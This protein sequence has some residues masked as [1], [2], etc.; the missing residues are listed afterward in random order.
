M[1]QISSANNPVLG[2]GFMLAA[3]IGFAAVNVATQYAGMVAGIHP[4]TT[5][6][7]QY[8]IA[9]LFAL[10]WIVR[11]GFGALATGHPI[12]HVG[13]VVLS[14]IGVQLWVSA[15]A[16]VPI[17]QGIAL[18]MTSPLFV[19]AGAVLFLGERATLLRLAATL[20]GFT[21]ALIIL[22][23]WSATFTWYA[24]LPIGA[25]ALWAGVTLLTKYLTRDEKSESITIYLLL[26]LTPINAAFFLVGG[27]VLPD[28]SG[29]LVLIALGLATVFAQYLLTR[30][31]AVADATYLQPFDDLKLPLNILLGWLVFATAPDISFWPGAALIVAASLL[32]MQQEA[33]KRRLSAA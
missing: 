2:A 21:G 20:M 29:W 3:G 33:A 26:L 14:A 8:F 32:I 15:L 5:A 11:T 9:L 28:A 12:L 13:R 22:Q 16:V 7:F 18:L 23:P 6:F 1:S 17:W 24:L 19:V 30:A 25:A 4:A 27:A 31:Y 10:P